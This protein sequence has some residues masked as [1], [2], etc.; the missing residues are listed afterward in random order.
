[1]PSIE[2]VIVA[3]RF[4]DNEDESGAESVS[5]GTGTAGVYF[6]EEFHQPQDRSA[7]QV[8]LILLQPLFG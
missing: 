4:S 1:M 6:R 3:D 8:R 2:E 7:I 5:T